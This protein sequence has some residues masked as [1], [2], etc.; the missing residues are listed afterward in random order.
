M[1][2]EA[3][4]ALTRLAAGKEV[5]LRCGARKT[6]RHGYALAQVFV[7][8]ARSGCGFSTS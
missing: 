6:D 8:D 5:E 3:K 7:M 1:V 4:D 2:E